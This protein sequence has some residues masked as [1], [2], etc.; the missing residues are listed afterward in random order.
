MAEIDLENSIFSFNRL[1]LFIC[2]FLRLEFSSTQVIFFSLFN[3]FP[4]HSGC[5]FSTFFPLII[6]FY[7]NKNRSTMETHTLM[8]S[9]STLTVSNIFSVLGRLCPYYIHHRTILTTLSPLPQLFFFPFDLHSI[10]LV[11]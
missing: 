6:F 2:L 3:L 11:F 9:N 4:P 7:L 5:I 8:S 10:M 1:F